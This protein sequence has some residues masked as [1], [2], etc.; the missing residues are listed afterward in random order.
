MGIVYLI[1]NS[2]NGKVYVGKTMKTLA[3]RWRS[4]VH[5]AKQGYDLLLSRAIRKYGSENFFIEELC[6][7]ESEDELNSL[8]QFHIA[9]L[10]S[11]L[12]DN[13]YNAT[14]GGDGLHDTTGEVRRRIGQKL[15]GRPLSAQHKSAI[16][17]GFTEKSREQ[18]K[19][20]LGKL[21]SYCKNG[22]EL[23]VNNVYVDYLGKRHCRECQK[24]AGKRFHRNHPLRRRIE[25]SA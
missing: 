14:A 25:V 3:E 22:H 12:T 6:Q 13:G 17:C 5:Y 18:T 7:A 20:N 11:Y 24:E 10:S 15:R 16:Y 19:T 8:E 2:V 21:K 4:H 23:G 9:R 1:T